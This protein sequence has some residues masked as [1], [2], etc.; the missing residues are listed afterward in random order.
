MRSGRDNDHAGPSANRTV[1]ISANSTAAP[2]RRIDGSASKSTPKVITL[3]SQAVSAEAVHQVASRP[4]AAPMPASISPSTTSCWM[5]CRRPP[6]S[7]WR[8]AISF[9]RAAPRASSRL[10]RFRQAT[11]STSPAI[12]VSSPA[13][14]VNGPS[15][16]GRELTD[17]RGRLETEN[18]RSRSVPGY[19]A[20]RLFAN[21]SSAV[22]AAAWVTP[23]FR[24]PARFSAW[25]FRSLS[26]LSL[27]LNI[28]LA[29]VS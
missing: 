23:G 18:V 12:S 20:S 25:F 27:S 15:P 22:V 4:N 24:A 26:P 14:A 9:R 10:A 5:I 7:A 21:R 8:T 2:I 29:I 19:C 3:D 28:A 1:L 16:C 11:T 13:T 17:M 6:P